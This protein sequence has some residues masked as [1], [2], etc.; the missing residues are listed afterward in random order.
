MQRRRSDEGL[1][2]HAP[3]RGPK[4]PR[5]AGS[6]DTWGA[7]IVAHVLHVEDDPDLRKIMGMVLTGSPLADQWELDQVGSV[8]QAR[9]AMGTWDGPALLLTDQR[10]PDGDGLALAREARAAYGG[11]RTVILTAFADMHPP[12]YVDEVVEKPWGL[13][14]MEQA[15]HGITKR[16]LETWK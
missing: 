6:C 16:W 8:S 10:L 1:S 7:S 4:P 3:W 12:E 13:D 9:Q 14:G 11:V 15:L 5:P 2:I